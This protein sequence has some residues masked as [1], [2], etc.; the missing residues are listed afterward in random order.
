MESE[1]LTLCVCYNMSKCVPRRSC[2][3]LHTSG[4]E[5]QQEVGGALITCSTVVM[6]EHYNLTLMNFGEITFNQRAGEKSSGG[7]LEGS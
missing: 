3:Y 1:S 2:V 5:A 7:K 4:T 6:A